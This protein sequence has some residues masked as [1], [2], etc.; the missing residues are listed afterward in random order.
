[1]S[2]K[3]NTNKSIKNYSARKLNKTKKNKQKGGNYSDKIISKIVEIAKDIS[4]TFN[5]D[6]FI[7][8][9]NLHELKID[10]KLKDIAHIFK[11]SKYLEL[12]KYNGE[13]KLVIACGNYRLDDRNLDICLSENDCDQTFENKYH[14]HR[15]CYTIDLSLVANPS[16]VSNFDNPN[17]IYKTIPSNSFDLIFFE[18]GGEPNTNP[19][20]IKRLLNSNT[21]SFCLAMNEGKYIVYSYWFEG[22]YI[23]N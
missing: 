2:K 5:T 6:E 1:M 7:A 3:I 20:E 19:N 13:K 15:D 21:N 18:G 10:N 9:F 4:P 17:I 23:I 14:S 12:R 16:I 22:R 11:E 8:P